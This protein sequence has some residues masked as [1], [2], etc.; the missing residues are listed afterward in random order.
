MSGETRAP[1]AALKAALER[2]RIRGRGRT[3]FEGQEPYDDELMLAEIENLSRENR[4]L[5]AAL[6]RLRDCD[7][8][9]TPLDRMDGVRGIARAALNGGDGRPHD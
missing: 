4:I 7:W 2:V 9:I 5:R 1:T 8:T 3:R 6:T